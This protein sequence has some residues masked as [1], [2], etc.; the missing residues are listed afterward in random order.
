MADIASALGLVPRLAAE[1]ELRARF[2]TVVMR[3]HA[4]LRVAVSKRLHDEGISKGKA[5]ALLEMG[6]GWLAR[7]ADVEMTPEEEAGLVERVDAALEKLREAKG[8]AA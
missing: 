6:R 3:A 8:N 7:Y 5:S 2:E 1:P 4:S